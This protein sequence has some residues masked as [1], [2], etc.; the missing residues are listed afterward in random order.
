[1]VS[2][3][4]KSYVHLANKIL[5]HFFFVVHLILENYLNMVTISNN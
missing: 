4:S 5:T 3:F 1:M 2:I